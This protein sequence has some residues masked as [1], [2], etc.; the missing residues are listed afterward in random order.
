MDK[1]L[2]YDVSYGMYVV[3]TNYQNKNV[4]CIVNTFSQITSE[5]M[6]VMISLNK[7]NY[8]NKAV[9]S[10]GK[11]CLSILSEKTNPEI[12][13]KFGF[14]TSKD[15]DKFKDFNCEEVNNLPFVNENMCGYF[16]CEI[17]FSKKSIE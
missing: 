3:S 9:K 15:T 17:I 2:F 7:E 4:G 16:I 10:V 8:T 13:G 11:F 5:D 6:V 14:Y 1:N 12:I